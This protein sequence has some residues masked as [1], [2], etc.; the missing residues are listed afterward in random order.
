[1]R[2]R[3]RALAKRLAAV[4]RKCRRCRGEDVAGEAIGF[5]H[6]QGERGMT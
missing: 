4:E 6:E 1:L 2:N 3:V 5:V